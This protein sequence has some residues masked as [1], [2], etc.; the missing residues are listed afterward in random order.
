MTK[1]EVCMK[2]DT[3]DKEFS[4]DR[5]VKGVSDHQRRESS[6]SNHDISVNQV[7]GVD[8]RVNESVLETC[9]IY[10]FA[11]FGSKKHRTDSAELSGGKTINIV[12]NDPTQTGRELRFVRTLNSLS[13]SIMVLAEQ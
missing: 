11:W 10:G 9:G 1:G 3:D 6:C 4:R 2:R 8:G 5:E 7:I 13:F 12:V